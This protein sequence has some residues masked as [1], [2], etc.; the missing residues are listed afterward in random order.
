MISKKLKINKPVNFNKVTKY[1]LK[2][3]LKNKQICQLIKII[4]LTK[5]LTRVNFIKKNIL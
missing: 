5:M 1:W 3:S 2:I 4:L